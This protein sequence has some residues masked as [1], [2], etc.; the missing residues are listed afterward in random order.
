MPN[1]QGST[2]QLSCDR[3]YIDGKFIPA[4]LTIGG[5]VITRIEP[6]ADTHV[7]LPKDTVLLPGLIDTHVHVNEPGR[8][9][10]EGFATATAAA[11]SGGIATIIDMPLNSLPAT[12]TPEALAAKRE[13]AAAKAGVNIGFWGG[14]VPSNLGRLGELYD[15]GVFGFKAFLSPSGI[16]DFP[17]LSAAQFD[18]AAREIA[19]FDGL[20]IVHAE[21]PELL[22]PHGALGR[23]YGDYLATRPPES[24]RSAVAGVI[25]TARTTGARI[26]ILH[27]SDASSL[28]ALRQAKE[29]GLRITVETCPHYLALRAE[30]VPDGAPEFKCCPPIREN[31]NQDLLWQGVLDGTIDTVGSDHSPN[32]VATKRAGNGDFGLSWGGVS[33]LEVGFQATWSAAKERGIPLERVVDL[34]TAGPGR[35]LGLPHGGVLGTGAPADLTVIAPERSFT[36]D[37]AELHHRHPISAYHGRTLAGPA[38]ATWV[39]GVLVHGDAPAGSATPASTTPGPRPGR[40]L[41]RR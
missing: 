13:V 16:D 2:F 29:E 5:G 10:W 8:T 21:D 39:N 40:L 27:L 18:A 31:A 11:A 20:L 35:L 34:Y 23:R 38:V 9:E 30:D 15:E 6:G 17:Q 22:V 36:V 14:A 26:H 24:E 41:E 19:G 37:A 32:P 4:T 3:A 7:R 28:P 1:Q 12:T 25:E 33:G